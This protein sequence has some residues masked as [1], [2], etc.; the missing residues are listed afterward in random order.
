MN[1]VRLVARRE[2]TERVRER[3]FLISTGITLGSSCS[4]WCCRRCSASAARRVHG[5][6]RRRRRAAP[7]AERAGRA[8]RTSSTSKLTVT[9]TSTADVTL[10]AARSAPTTSPTTTL[11]NSCRSPTS[12][13]T[14]TPSRRCASSPTEPVDP[15]RDA[16]AGLAFFT[17]LILYGQLLTYGFWVATGVVEEKSSRVIEILLATI[18]PQRPARGQGDRARPAR[19]RAAADRRPRSGSS[20]RRDRARGRRRAT[21]W[22]RSRSRSAGSCSA[23]PSTRRPYAV[24]GGAGAA[25]GG[26]P[27]LDDAADDADPGLAVR[28]LRGQRQPGRDARPRGRVHPADRAGHDA[29]RGSSSA[30]RPRGRSRRRSR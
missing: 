19:A 25:P 21:S 28:R 26:D 18:R 11:V 24:G 7:I 5:R 2:F 6:R 1:I 29:R 15:D 17:I 30:P 13:S 23:T 22:S 14:P 4:C 9:A 27:E 12:S 20:W 10:A 8:R 3:S 16:K